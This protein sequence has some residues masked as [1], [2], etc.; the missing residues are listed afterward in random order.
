MPEDFPLLCARFATSKLH[1]YDAL[2]QVSSFG[3]RGE[4]LCALSYAGSVHVSSVRDGRVAAATFRD[5][6]PL[7]TPLVEPTDQHSGT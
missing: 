5:A 4:A 1:E 2:P 3:F 7:A 6:R